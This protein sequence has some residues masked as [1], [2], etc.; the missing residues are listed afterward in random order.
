HPARE[1]QI[2]HPHPVAVLDLQRS[3]TA[4]PTTP[5]S[6]DQLHLQLDPPTMIEHTNQGQ[7]LEPTQ[8]AH[9]ILHP[10]FLLFRVFDNAKPA[11]SS[12]CL[13]SGPQPRPF[14]KTREWTE[15]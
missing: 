4:P 8:P 14:N 10:L 11:R 3:T 1:R 13:L 2:P 6:S 7:H 15:H 9:V 12:G 5:G